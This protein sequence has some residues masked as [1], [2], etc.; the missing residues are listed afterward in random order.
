[1]Q[2]YPNAFL[3]GGTTGAFMQFVMRIMTKEALCVRP[4]SY[5]RWGIYGFFLLGYWDWQRRVTLE[6]VL[7]KEEDYRY[8]Q[9]VRAVNKARIGTEDDVGYLTE[10][11]ATQTTKF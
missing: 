5:V 6:T 4:F 1:M 8:K 10:Y 11:L 7:A 3:C 9:R 2:K